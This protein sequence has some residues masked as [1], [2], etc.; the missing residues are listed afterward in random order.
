VH[1]STEQG[2]VAL[3]GFGDERATPSRNQ[4]SFHIFPLLNLQLNMD[5]GATDNPQ[6]G[7]AS[8]SCLSCKERKQKCD[9]ALPDCSRCERWVHSLHFN[10]QLMSFGR[11]LLKCHYPKPASPHSPPLSSNGSNGSLDGNEA[12]IQGFA[13]IAARGQEYHGQVLNLILEHRQHFEDMTDTFFNSYHKWVPIVHQESFREYR[14]ATRTDICRGLTT[15]TLSMCLITRPFMDGETPNP[16][17]LSL[18]K[19]LSR[20]FW[21]PESIAQPTLPLIQSGVILSSYEYGQGTSDAAYMTI[22]T[23]LSMGQVCGLG[24]P[25]PGH[26]QIQYPFPGIWTPRDEGLRTWW[27]SLIHERSVSRSSC[28]LPDQDYIPLKLTFSF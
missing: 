6:S 16:L 20:L 10:S 28:P 24:K 22:C 25:P 23:C 19:A 4:T 2:S 14:N 9:K 5:L 15:L 27:A 7:L 8:M 13:S 1:P 17:R 18:Y 26:D 21:D 3:A 11:L 12:L